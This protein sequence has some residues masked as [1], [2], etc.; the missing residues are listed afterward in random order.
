MDRRLAIAATF[1]EKQKSSF[2]TAFV[3]DMVLKLWWRCGAI[4]GW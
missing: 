4:W 1:C 3:K 2:A